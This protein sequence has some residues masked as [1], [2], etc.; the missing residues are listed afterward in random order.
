MRAFECKMCGTCC[1]GK[2]GISVQRNEIEMIAD[3]LKISPD[4]FIAEYCYEKNDRISIRTGPDNFCIFYHKKKGCLI[5]RF[6]PRPCSLWPFYPAILK[7]A[8]NWETTKDAC[9]GINPDCSFEEFVKESKRF[10]NEYFQPI[11]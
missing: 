2:G 3:F 6:K 9:P 8:D 11:H 5:H 4:S 10:R 7:D 1:Y